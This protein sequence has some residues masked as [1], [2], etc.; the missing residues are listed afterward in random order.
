MLQRPVRLQSPVG[1]KALHWPD[2]QASPQ[3]P[4]HRYPYLTLESYHNTAGI[5]NKTIFVMPAHMDWVT[6]ASLPCRQHMFKSVLYQSLRF[7]QHNR[8]RPML[9]LPPHEVAPPPTITL[10]SF[11]ASPGLSRFPS[12][13]SC[14]S[15]TSPTRCSLLRDYVKIHMLLLPSEQH[16]F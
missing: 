9:A 6:A 13:D 1:R 5:V 11:P 12:E 16:A 4:A 15:S 3:I 7:T 8:M 2:S 10:N 14:H